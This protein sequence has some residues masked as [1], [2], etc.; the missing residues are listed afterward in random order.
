[1]NLEKIYTTKYKK[2]LLIP[3]L[4]LVLSILVLGLQ[5]SSKG[6][7]I[8]KDVTLKGG[9]S[10][11]IHTN[12]QINKDEI[13]NKLKQEF[14][15]SDISIRELS[16]FGTKQKKG[17]I[18]EAT[19][20]T[21]DQITEFIN[22]NIDASDTSIQETG[23]TLG[24]SFFKELV[25]AILIAFILISIVVLI[26]FRKLIPSLAI[27]L[28]IILDLTAT[29]A[30]ISLLNV[31]ISSAGI[32]AFLMVLGYSID[33]DILLTTR[34]LK[35]KQGTIFERLKNAFKTGILMTITTLTALGIGFLITNSEILKQMFG[36]ILI[37]LI[38][39]IV[40]TWVMNSA[41][42]IWYIKKNETKETV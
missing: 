37:A 18:I 33:T 5:Y 38:I 23:P 9:I 11:T 24:S 27:I 42:L 20:I 3:A 22:N 14:P 13:L 2:L 25:V 10:A 35:R 34:L 30:I 8:D 36:I 32:A 28:S 15:N 7:F 31:K 6:Y 26:A 39:D 16:S 40:S 4:I 1:M 21:S 29:L 17:I 41:M 19:D 12:S